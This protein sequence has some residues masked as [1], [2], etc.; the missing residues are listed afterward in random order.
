MSGWR[1]L[2]P[3]VLKHRNAGSCYRE[4]TGKQYS[5]WKNQNLCLFIPFY[6]ARPRSALY[7][8]D[9][10]AHSPSIK[11][12]NPQFFHIIDARK[13]AILN[14]ITKTKTP[15]RTVAIKVPVQMNELL[16]RKI[17]KWNHLRTVLRKK[18]GLHQN[19][20]MIIK[21]HFPVPTLLSHWGSR[22]VPVFFPLWTDRILSLHFTLLFPPHH[23]QTAVCVQSSWTTL[24]ERPCSPGGTVCV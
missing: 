23:R 5:P 15:R 16:S 6:N 19:S 2:L 20:K 22:T 13:A 14:N 24:R 8:K 10:H 9:T 21:E 18:T 11:P 17:P 4:W 1:P 7:F 12:S 3:V